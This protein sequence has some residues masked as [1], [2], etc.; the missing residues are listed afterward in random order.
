MRIIAGKMKGLSIKAVP[1]HSTRPTTDK[2]RESIFNMI[3]PYFQNEVGLDLYAGSGA[4]GIEALSRGF[5]KVIFVDRD[6]KAVQTINEN[7]KR[8]HFKE[9]AEVYRND[10]KIALKALKKR[11]IFFSY[12]FLDPPY[13]KTTVS[14][15]ETIQSFGLLSHS[16]R[17][18]VEHAKEFELH[19][20]IGEIVRTK[21]ETYGS[22]SISIFSY[23]MN[24]RGI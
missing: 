9:N 22:T 18:I 3:G 8:S 1:G 12:I 13:N 14:D 21:Y 15:I 19:N 5:S 24:T 4:L 7:L 23:K 17:I 16:G 2:V 20:Q 6:Y 10:A 11:N